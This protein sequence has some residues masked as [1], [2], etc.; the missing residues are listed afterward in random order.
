MPRVAALSAL[1]LEKETGGLCAQQ[2]LKTDLK[3]K[4]FRAKDSPEKMA[5]L[6][7]VFQAV[8]DSS[9]PLVYVGTHTRNYRGSRA[10]PHLCGG[11]F[12]ADCFT[13]TVHPHDSSPS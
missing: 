11:R 13:G 6:P 12:N 5:I 3:L 4:A 9:L 10:A 2:T 8:G 7:L 1:N